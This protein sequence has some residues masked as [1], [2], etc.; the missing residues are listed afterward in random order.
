[1]LLKLEA[2]ASTDPL[3]GL[4]NRRA[5]EEAF[6]V[7]LARAG[8]GHFGVGVVMLD[9]D[10]FKRFNDDTGTRPEMSRSSD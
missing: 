5:L 9:L 3:T 4:L 2:A 7:E 1:M 8:R 6:D 10:G